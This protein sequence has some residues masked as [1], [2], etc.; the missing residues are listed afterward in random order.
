M[1]IG[2]TVGLVGGYWAGRHLP[3]VL[4]VLP[5][6]LLCFDGSALFMATHGH[7]EFFFGSWFLYIMCA[8]I[9]ISRKEAAQAVTGSWWLRNLDIVALAVLWIALIIANSLWWY[10][11]RL[12][13]IPIV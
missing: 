1:F 7:A 6:G 3:A 5:A 13:G 4:R 10:Y 11:R 9:G 2:V 8:S 12:A